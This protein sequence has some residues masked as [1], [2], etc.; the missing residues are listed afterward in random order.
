M[1]NDRIAELL[2]SAAGEHRV[3]PATDL[4]NEGWM[5]RLVLDWFSRNPDVDYDLTLT[6][7]SGPSIGASA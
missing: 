7:I 4:Y 2:A 5:L 6:T 3:F 1:V